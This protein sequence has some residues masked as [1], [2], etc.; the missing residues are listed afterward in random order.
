MLYTCIKYDLSHVSLLSRN[1]HYMNCS[2]SLEFL[3]G[4]LESIYMINFLTT[5]T[6]TRIICFM[7]V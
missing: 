5:L 7:R 1:L 3:D 4:V 6:T 2:S